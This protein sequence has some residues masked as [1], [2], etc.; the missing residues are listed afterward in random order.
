MYPRKRLWKGL[1]TEINDDDNAFNLGTHWAK[2]GIVVN[3]SQPE[4]KCKFY[5]Q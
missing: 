2:M 3:F 1:S 4:E 5:V